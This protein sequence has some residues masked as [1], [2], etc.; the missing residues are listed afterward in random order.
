MANMVIYYVLYGFASILLLYGQYYS[1]CNLML[2]LRFRPDF[3]KKLTMALSCLK[4]SL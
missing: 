1:H 4:T 2:L 3:D